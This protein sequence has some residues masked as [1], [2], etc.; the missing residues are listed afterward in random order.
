[1]NFGHQISSAF[2]SWVAKSATL[3]RL[4]L[5]F[6]I[7]A[8]RRKSGFCLTT[9]MDQFWRRFIFFRISSKICLVRHSDIRGTYVGGWNMCSV[10][11][12]QISYS[13]GN[14]NYWL[15][16]ENSL[17]MHLNSSTAA[18]KK[19]SS[20]R[21]VRQALLPN[22]SL[23]GDWWLQ[24]LLLIN[25]AW[26]VLSLSDDIPDWCAGFRWCV[27]FYLCVRTSPNWFDLPY[28]IAPLWDLCKNSANWACLD[29]EK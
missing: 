4:L 6:D 28:E 7:H 22:I 17:K 12:L 25:Y 8:R 27:N 11:L 23:K 13:I 19:I 15:I 10:S 9:L 2:T 29:K 26:Y 14:T 3:R 21:R 18:K 20:W 16:Q 24:D 1:M 5:I